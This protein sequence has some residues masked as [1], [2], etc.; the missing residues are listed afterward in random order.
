ME[1]IVNEDRVKVTAAEAYVGKVYIIKDKTYAIKL[2]ERDDVDY[3]QFASF[4]GLI[5]HLSPRDEVEPVYSA[6]VIIE[7]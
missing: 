6:K 7:E 1:V 3:S 4:D 5:Y 2:N